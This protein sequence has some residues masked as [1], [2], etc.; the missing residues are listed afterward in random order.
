MARTAGPTIDLIAAG[1]TFSFPQRSLEGFADAHG[2]VRWLAERGGVSTANAI[3]Y[4]KLAARLKRTG[5]LGQPDALQHRVER[6]AAR[7]Y[8][9]WIR[10]TYD[11]RVSPVLRAFSNA[12]VTRGI[13][14][15]RR[16]SLV[17]PYPEKVLYRRL[18]PVPPKI[19]EQ[20]RIQRTIAEDP[21]PDKWTLHVPIK[22]GVPAHSDPC[23]DCIYVEVSPEQLD[24]IA[25]AFERAWGHRQLDGVPAD[26]FL[27]GQPPI[28]LI[29]ARAEVAKR[30]VGLVKDNDSA[31][32]GA[33]DSI[34]GS[35]TPQLDVFATRVVGA[36]AVLIDFEAVPPDHIDHVLTLVRA[37]FFQCDAVPVQTAPI[38]TSLPVGGPLPGAPTSAA[39]IAWGV[40]EAEP[41]PGETEI[42]VPPTAKPEPPPES[43]PPEAAPA[44]ALV[45]P[46]PVAPG[47][48]VPTDWETIGAR[49]KTKL[50]HCTL[51]RTQH[52]VRADA[53]PC[54]AG[55]W[56]EIH[57]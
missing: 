18:L 17:P 26:A 12:D 1:R 40:L 14:R 35:T 19:G 41:P 23:P 21:C 28:E 43:E 7:A 57:A 6:T 24:V 37:A 8:W 45:P 2:F 55:A 13:R 3:Y 39:P 47:E 16:S 53:I 25:K 50:V 52:S 48:F 5:R 9:K 36:T 34:G 4:V 46:D 31:C 22:D 11:D 51:H 38:V 33:I 56:T 42:I 32:A 30:V 27:F 49:Y 44:I 10:E 29:R 54:A 20:P 15:L